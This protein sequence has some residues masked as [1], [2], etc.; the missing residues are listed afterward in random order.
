MSIKISVI[1]PSL[2]SARYL[3]EAI[4]SV[5]SQ[6]HADWE[7]IV[8]DGGSTDGTLDIL[9]DCPWVRWI[10]E[11]DSGQSN[12]MN[13]GFA[14]AGGDVIVYLNA[15]DYFLPGAFSAVRPWFEQGA[16][17]VVGDVTVRDLDGGETRV[18]PKV[19]YRQMLRHWEPW[20]EATDRVI[21]PHPNNPV[22]YFYRREIQ[23]G[24]PFNEANHNSMD[25]EF[26]L[27]VAKDCEFTKID[28]L[29]GV[30]RLLE[31]AK[32]VAA[33]KSAFS[34]WTC[35]NFSYVDE[36]I[37]D[38]PAA[39]I[40]AFKIDQQAGYVQ[41]LRRSMQWAFRPVSL[42][43]GELMKTSALRAPAGKWR[44]YKA[45]IRALAGYAKGLG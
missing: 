41:A 30:Y 34:Y 14:M 32:N 31:D 20:V 40:Q 27:R 21:S 35:Q 4:D 37:S 25:L 24:L 42:A 33:Q 18:S 26:L 3:R 12:A 22:Q 43:M 44:A 15:D 29:L 5:R 11:P 1:T 17:F 23:A 38:W 10:S 13:K 6:D 19:G 9:R 2:N 28:N 8:V 45:L 16:R 36:L 39:D 7:H